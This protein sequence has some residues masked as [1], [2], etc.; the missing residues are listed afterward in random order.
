MTRIGRLFES[1]KHENRKG[2]IAYL[3]AGDPSPLRTP[4][5]VAAMVR[6]GA[7]I[8]LMPPDSVLAIRVLRDAVKSGRI[9]ESRIDESVE[10]ILRAKARLRLHENRLV[11]LTKIGTQFGDP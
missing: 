9:S 3:T 2:L 1:L 8:L 11:D 6:G 4:A 10:R 7:D 5:L